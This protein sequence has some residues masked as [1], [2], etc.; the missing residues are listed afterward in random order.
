MKNFFFQKKT[1]LDRRNLLKRGAFILAGLTLAPVTR[2]AFAKKNTPVKRNAK[3]RYI[4]GQAGYKV[5]HTTCLG[6]NARCGMRAVVHD[7]RL[8]EVS[9][10]P[11]HPY[12]HAFNPVPFTTP[13]SDTTTLSSPV[14]AKAKEAPNIAYSPYR[15][16]KPLKR[17]GA[18]GSGKFEPIEWNQLI[19]EIA[20]GGQLF[21]SIGDPRQYPGLRNYMRDDLIDPAAPELGSVRNQLV[22]IGGRDQ[23]GYKEFTDRFVRS[24]F[25]SINRISHTDICGL[26]FRMGNFALSGQKQVEL[27][28]DPLNAEYVLVF[29][30]NIYE[31]LQPGIT[32][33]G[34]ILAERHAK[35]EVK[36]T[37]VDPRSTNA[38]VHGH[39][40][41]PVKP[42]KDGALAMALIRWIIEN[43]AYDAS[44]LSAPNA[45]MAKQLKRNCHSNAT[46]L[47]ITDATHPRQGMFLRWKDITAE[48]DEKAGNAFVVL[49]SDG[50]ARP[51]TELQQAQLEVATTLTDLKGQPITV[52]SAFTILKEEAQSHSLSSYADVCGVP[53]KDLIA[54]AKEFSAHGHKAAVCQYH[55]AGNY[56]NGAYAAYAIAVLSALVGSIDMRG[57]YLKGGGAAGKWDEGA[58]DLKNFP[59]VRKP[60]GVRISREKAVYEKSTEFK[61]KLEKTGSGY[62]AKR[63]WFAFTQG[64]LCVESL[65]GIAQKY[66][67]QC[68]VL[69]TYYFNPIYSIPGG[70]TFVA[71]LKDPDTLPL[72][73]SIDVGVNESNI[74]A[75]YIV[76]ALTYLEGQYG[77]L[78][79]HAPAMK[80]TAVR[81][82]AITPLT[83]KTKDN[84][85]FSLETFLIDLAEYL[86]L[87]GFGPNAIPGPDGA[88]LALHSAEDFYMRGITN[89]AL[90]TKQ[91]AALPA[92]QQYVEKDYPAAAY[93]SL[94]SPEEWSSVCH[95]LARGGVF[96][97]RYE[98]DFDANE[99]HIHGLGS[100]FI[101][102]EQMASAIDS[103]T[104]ER[105]KGHPALE[106]PRDSTGTLIEQAD[107]EYPLTLVT[108]K[109]NVHAQSRSTWHKWS[110]ELFPQNYIIIHPD[111]AARLSISDGD[112]VRVTSRHCPGGVPGTVKAS[113]SVRPGC[114]AVSFHYGHTQLGASPLHVQ[115]APTVFLGGKNVCTSKGLTGNPL[116]GRGILPNKLGRLDTNLGN[117][118]LVDVLS[119]IPDFSSTRIAISKTSSGG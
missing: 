41:L 33:Y 118:P 65:S 26:G 71:A 2:T 56:M 10:N 66:P 24:A 36:F 89:L 78:T 87:P 37:I 83:G 93:K 97:R 51:H 46:H 47:V 59:G 98:D 13:V 16:I 75:D 82:P 23:A 74:Y 103:L 112:N 17:T 106:L 38:S 81:T 34:A 25:G 110:M 113:A 48:P 92:E 7:N 60:G 119:G 27:K 90:N 61:N 100:I 30:A 102:N 111:D 19:R 55:G 117:M 115:K 73:V 49:A 101:Y 114:A 72:H 94:L 109:M 53:E 9:G 99:C 29:G 84:R 67:Y 96:N 85:H 1:K 31:A 4:P 70:D 42:G 32:T 62:P 15:I 20:D 5:V 12:N 95:V 22:F 39:R 63:P 11:F 43:K 105:F 40:W 52:K 28:A 44:F 45:D 76:P 91:P 69:F 3:N 80:F 18:R 35:G 8:V 88:I 54:V 57:G 6:C 116:L 14:C 64:G 108:Y 21:S 79:P 58:Y 77:F 68:G 107:K 104:G 86:K 50:T